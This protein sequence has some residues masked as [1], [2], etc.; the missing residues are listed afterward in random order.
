[1]HVVLKIVIVISTLV[2]GFALGMWITRE[3]KL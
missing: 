1:M 2:A 3:K